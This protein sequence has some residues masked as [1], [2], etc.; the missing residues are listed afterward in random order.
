MSGQDEKSVKR[1]K[2]AGQALKAKA[3]PAVGGWEAFR[4]D[5]R[6]DCTLAPSLVFFRE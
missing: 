4:Y 5:F 1:I 6:R 3:C 2:G